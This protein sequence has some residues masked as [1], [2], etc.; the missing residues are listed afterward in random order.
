MK[1]ELKFEGVFPANPTPFRD[2]KV[3]EKALREIF[4][5]NI[6][7][8][9]NGFWVAGSTGEGP[10]LSDSQREIV[11]RIAGETCSGRC[12]SIMHVGAISTESA[13]KGASAAAKSGCDAV[14]CVPPFFFR[15]T[16]ETVVEHYKRVSEAADGLP[17]FIYNLPQL[18]QVE[19][20]PS[21]ME[22]IVDK[23]PNVVGLKHSAPNFQDIKIFSDMGLKCFSGNGALPL[24]ALTLGAVG[25]VDAP[26]SISPWHYVSLY[27]AWKNGDISNAK[28]L[29]DGISKI[30]SITRMFDTPAH[31]TKII[32]SERTG[33]D[34]GIPIP[35]VKTLN[36]SEKSTVMELAGE[37]GL[38]KGPR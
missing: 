36:E 14:C 20:T 21:M 33:V 8:G 6:S 30:V 16:V 10:V 15:S 7:H 23:V 31:V 38:L 1:N 18:T 9:V 3:L 19:T 34:C 27:K 24:P 22:E 25:T 17:F 4:E 13:V 35:P 12:L 37:A 32:L 11:A 2:G 26:L 29:Q 5:D 28:K